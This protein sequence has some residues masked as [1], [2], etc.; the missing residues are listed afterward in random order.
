MS[1]EPSKHFEEFRERVLADPQ[2]LERLRQTDGNEEFLSSAE[3][4]ARELG[5]A[6]T[7]EEIENALHSARRE[8]ME[9]WLQ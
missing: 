1:A 9:R 6:I 8:W 7:R 4:T 5:F 2:L 3:A